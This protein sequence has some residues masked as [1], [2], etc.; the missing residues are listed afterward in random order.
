MIAYLSDADIEFPVGSASFV[1]NAGVDATNRFN[2]AQELMKQVKEGYDLIWVVSDFDGFDCILSYYRDIGNRVFRVPTKWYNS[3]NAGSLDV[4]SFQ[5]DNVD[6]YS[7][8]VRFYKTGDVVSLLKRIPRYNVN[9]LLLLFNKR[10]E[11]SSM[12]I[13][14]IDDRQV[15]SNEVSR[16]LDT[17]DMQSFKDF[18]KLYVE[19]YNVKIINNL[20][21][22]LAGKD[23]GVF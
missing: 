9:D 8:V 7:A 1:Y 11:E 20:V 16:Y 22:R 23:L 6:I 19:K 4:N 13:L 2:L 14:W 3:I 10:L 15:I 18:L 21:N 5:Y 17:G 12:D